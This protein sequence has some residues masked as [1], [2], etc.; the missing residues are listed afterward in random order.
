MAELSKM[1]KLISLC[2][3][4]GFIFPSSEI[5]GGYS[6]IYDF[7][8]LGVELSNNIKKAWWRMFVRERDD[9]VGLDSSI[10]MSP[11]IWE[12]SG[13]VQ[14][15]SDPLVD[16]K[17]C[18]QR[19]RADHLLESAGLKPGYD[20]DQPLDTKGL[21][22]PE[23]GG[24]LTE[25]RQFN[26]MFKTQVGSMEGSTSEAYLRPETAGGIFVNYKNVQQTMRKK[27]PFGIGQI[28][29]AFRNEIT[30]ENYIFRVREFEQM[31]I[32][33]FIKPDNWE[34]HFEELLNLMKKWC[35]YLGLKEANLVY[36]EIAD[37][38]RA[39]YSKR[40]IDIEYNYPFGQKE[41]YGLAYRTDYDLGR[42]QKFS[43]EDLTYLDPE[44]N[45]KTLPHV[46]EPSFGL[47]RTI[48]A[49]LSEAFEE[50]K[51]GRST[52]TESNKEE[53]MVLRLPYD[54]APVKI[55]IFPL[56]K[57]EPLLG[58]AEDIA[59]DL[60]PFWNVQYDET[61]SV[62][63]RYRRQDEIGTPYCI[64]VDFDTPNDGKVTVRDR[65]TMEQERVEVKE[66]RNFFQKKLIY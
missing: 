54:L 39:F 17:K 62:G 36:H 18:H 58:I 45:E 53:E 24:E 56:S 20:K 34:K 9:M 32:E 19:F 44:T 57:K 21:K 61:G 52:T 11:K 10:L 15:F 66:L 49:V 55:A 37:E 46:I 59:K 40:T 27:L 26:L 12:A 22:C 6:A 60:C 13:H 16:C 28:G 63:K 35:A 8:P 64:T 23:C 42:H 31:E 51:G 2:K 4:R 14:N 25:S 1:D 43:G 30:V 48:L 41:L 50:V 47:Q 3:R 5:Y 38:E 7:G 33:Y 29:K 65:D